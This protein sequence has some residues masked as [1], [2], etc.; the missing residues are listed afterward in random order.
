[1]AIQEREIYN[2]ENLLQQ[3]AGGVN[4]M[5]N[6]MSAE[7]A[8]RI[9]GDA[10]LDGRIDGIVAPTGEAPSP[11]E[12]LDGRVGADGTV[13]QSLGDAIRHAEESGSVA[14]DDTLTHQGEAAESKKVGD[15]LAN[16]KSQLSALGL[17]VVDGALN[18]TYE[19]VAG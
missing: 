11:A 5:N 10:A 17:S 13:Y 3:I 4:G 16:V 9:A 1:M 7:E 12:I 2:I 14:I 19:E 6:K 15:E 18:I 8:A